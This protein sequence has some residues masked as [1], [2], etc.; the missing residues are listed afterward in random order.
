MNSCMC[1]TGWV[2]EETFFF[3]VPKRM[4]RHNF[5]VFIW[6]TGASSTVMCWKMGCY[7]L[8][9]FTLTFASCKPGFGFAYEKEAAMSCASCLSLR[10]VGTSRA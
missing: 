10:Y 8:S 6:R 4:E 7:I 9:G 3:R 2:A 5:R 1:G